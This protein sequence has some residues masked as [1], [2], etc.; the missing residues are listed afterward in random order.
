M[1]GKKFIE[2]FDR[3]AVLVL[4]EGIY[5]YVNS[6]VRRVYKAVGRP[7]KKEWVGL[8]GE[9]GMPRTS[10]MTTFYASAGTMKDKES[11]DE[12]VLEAI[13]RGE[14]EAKKE[15]KHGKVINSW[16][17]HAIYL[18]K[19]ENVYKVELCETIEK[20]KERKRK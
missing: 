13:K 4:S 12:I 18:C 10:A 7:Y 9:S 8:L 17:A 19:E 11:L 20:R 14:D 16:Y 2:T 6:T 15:L 5:K 1:K 3:S